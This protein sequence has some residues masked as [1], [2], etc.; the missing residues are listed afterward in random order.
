MN[1]YNIRNKLKNILKEN[2]GQIS[3]EF[4]IVLGVVILVALTVGI[5][6]KQSSARNVDRVTAAQS[7]FENS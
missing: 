6:L 7:G 4:I 2:K 5:F 3:L 1:K